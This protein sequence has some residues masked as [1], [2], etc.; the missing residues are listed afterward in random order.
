MM[1]QVFQTPSGGNWCGKAQNSNIQGSASS[2][3]SLRLP[4]NAS[5]WSCVAEA[6]Q[7]APDLIPCGVKI[8]RS[9]SDSPGNLFAEFI[10]TAPFFLYQFESVFY[11][12]GQSRCGFGLVQFASPDLLQGARQFLGRL[13]QQAF[14]EF[15]QI[16]GCLISSGEMYG[17]ACSTLPLRLAGK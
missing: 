10:K 13:P 15:R 17:H 6:S 8:E 9:G 1:T 2:A 14:R 5:T 7:P 3:F 16:D 11:V 12:A 4:R